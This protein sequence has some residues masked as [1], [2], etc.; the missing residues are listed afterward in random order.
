MAQDKESNFMDI[1]KS[2]FSPTKEENQNNES[3][4]VFLKL[5]ENLPAVIYARDNKNNLTHPV[6]YS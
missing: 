6:S 2:L 3:G 5:F 4:A 1:I